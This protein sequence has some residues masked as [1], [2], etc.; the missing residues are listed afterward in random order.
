[1][2]ATTHLGLNTCHTGQDQDRRL[3]LR[4]TQRAQNLVTRHVRQVK[5]QQANVVIVELAKVD[6]F[7]AEVGGVDVE[8]LRFEHQL[9]A[10]CRRT[11]VFNEQNAH[12]CPLSRRESGLGQRPVS[13]RSLPESDAA[14]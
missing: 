12:I 9:D 7:L 11:I 5:V 13:E 3:D 1:K 10:L 2:A 8:A 6:P 4:Q 14:T